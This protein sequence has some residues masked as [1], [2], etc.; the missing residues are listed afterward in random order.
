MSEAPDSG[1]QAEARFEVV[2]RRYGHLLSEEQLERVREEV[3]RHVQMAE[4]L[5]SV[6][7]ENGDEPFS[8]FHP[9][10]EEG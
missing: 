8:T 1:S 3:E 10:R 5:R 9:Y 6:P 7:L 2:R 4:A